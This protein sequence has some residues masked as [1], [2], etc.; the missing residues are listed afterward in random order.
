M[1]L[2]LRMICGDLLVEREHEAALAAPRALGHVLQAHDALADARNAGD[3]RR[4]AEEVAAVHERVEAR[5]AGGDARRRIERG[6]VVAARPARRLHP[7]VHL[8][9][10]GRRR[11]GRSAGPSESRVPRDLTISIDRTVARVTSSI[12]SRMTV[13]AIDSSGSATGRSSLK[14]VA[15]TASTA[16]RFSRWSPS[17]RT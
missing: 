3:D 14:A 12:R 10:R 8:D 6:G 5:H 7:P 2:A 4:A 17:T 9:A 11:S 16:V 1:L 13:S 15:S